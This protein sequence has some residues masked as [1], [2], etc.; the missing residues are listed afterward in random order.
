MTFDEAFY[1]L[2][3][4]DFKIRFSKFYFDRNLEKER[5]VFRELNPKKEKYVYVHDDP[6]RGFVIREQK[7]RQDLKIIKNDFRFNLFDMLGVIENA[8]E[9]HTMQTGMLDL[10]NSV[11]LEKPKIFLHAYVRKYSNFLHSKG[12]NK[13]EKID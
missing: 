10:I 4:L 8:E 6:D 9:V 12:I 3:N 13:V 7:Y 2:A 11:K 5:E 1:D